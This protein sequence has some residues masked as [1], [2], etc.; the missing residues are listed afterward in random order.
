MAA[1]RFPKPEVV[2]SAV[3]WSYLVEIWYPDRF[4]VHLPKQIPSLNLNPEVHFRLYGRHLEK[5]IWRHNSADNRPITT[6]FDRQMQNDTSITIHRSISKPQIEFQY[7]GRPFSEIGSSVIWAVDWY[8]L[9]EIWRADRFPPSQTNSV[10]KP[11]P[12][13]RFPTLLPPYWKIDMTS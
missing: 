11:Q 13:S 5:S 10:I 1:V 9:I 4:P 6:K 7:D 8:Y 2:I 3:D 12:G